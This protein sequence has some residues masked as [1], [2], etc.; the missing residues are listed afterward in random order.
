MAN[1]QDKG[2]GKPMSKQAIYSSASSHA[3]EAIDILVQEMVHGDN[4]N[5]RIGAARTLL[6]KCV[7]DLKATEITGGEG[8]PLQI[9]FTVATKEAKEEL[10][11]L[12]D[13]RPNSGN[14]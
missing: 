11:K 13:E 9:T 7:P 8:K 5:A 4:S 2:R 6:A 14:D 1:L 12:Y 3:M 10:E